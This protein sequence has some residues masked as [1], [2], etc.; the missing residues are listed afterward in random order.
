EPE[1]ERQ[2]RAA[3]PGHPDPTRPV[4]MESLLPVL[5]RRRPVLGRRLLL[6]ALRL[7][8]AERRHLLRAVLPVV[9]HHGRFVL[10]QIDDAGLEDRHLLVADRPARPL[11]VLVHLPVHRGGG[12]GRRVVVIAAEHAV[13]VDRQLED[14]GGRRLLAPDQREHAQRD[15]VA[16][17]RRR[18]RRA[19]LGDRGG[20]VG[21]LLGGA[22]ALA[23]HVHLAV[24]V[25]AVGAVVVGGALLRVAAGAG[26]G[27]PGGRAPGRSGRPL[28][29]EPV[30]RPA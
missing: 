4:A 12:V 21:V 27:A 5:R 2:R 6:P 11:G 20:L 3:A 7:L 18:G 17:R 19:G 8:D 16:I 13:L 25:N 14:V 24:L 22:H 15:P 26:D 23:V 10:G 28:A 9:H 1:P 30:P 29:G